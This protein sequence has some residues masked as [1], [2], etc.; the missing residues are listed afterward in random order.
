[1]MLDVTHKS[2]CEDF[3]HI[4]WKYLINHCAEANNKH[5]KEHTLSILCDLS[6]AFD[7]IKDKI[8]LIKLNHYGLLG[9]VFL[10][11][12]GLLIN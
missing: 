9:I 5:P 1:M 8:L 4:L 12:S 2:R 11:V 3:L 7:V 10:F 6:K